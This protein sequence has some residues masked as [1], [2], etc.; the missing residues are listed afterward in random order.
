[1]TSPEGGF[2]SSQD[3]DSEGH[4]GKLFV[5]KP[6]EVRSALRG[7]KS[8]LL[9][10][11]KSKSDATDAALLM[12]ANGVTERGNLEGKDILHRARDTDVLA[13]LHRLSAEEYAIMSACV[14]DTTGCEC[15]AARTLY[16]NYVRV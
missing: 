7:S 8:G 1:M 11:S 2:N 15:N 4:K 9:I 12:E 10:V 16:A 6:E 5:W 13:E 3:A 14:R